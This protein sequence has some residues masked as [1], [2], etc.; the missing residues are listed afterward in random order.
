MPGSRSCGATRSFGGG[1]TTH[2]SARRPNRKLNY[3]C[4]SRR[5]RCTPV[6][7]AAASSAVVPPQACSRLDT[8][9]SCFEPPSATVRVRRLI[10]TVRLFLQGEY[11]ATIPK[12]KV[13][14][15][16]GWTRY[17]RVG[18]RVCSH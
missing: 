9:T 18:G 10:A 13:A 6:T 3:H 14:R 1:S 11:L 15:V 16:Q 4:N 7:A 12:S 5:K 17:G 8:Q 2:T